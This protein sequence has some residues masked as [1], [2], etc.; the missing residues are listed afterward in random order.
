MS[1]TEAADSATRK[2]LA[3]GIIG[4]SIFAILVISG[5]AIG[6]A[7]SSRAETSRLVFSAV[8]P[9]LGTWVGTVLAFYFARDN[10]Q[11]AT[12]ST[13]RLAGIDA[14]TPVANVM[15]PEADFVAYDMTPGQAPADI[16]LTALRERM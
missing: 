10:L 3:A 5:L 7:G 1:R 2:W 14:G 4:A 9:L 6:L 8:L 16:P 12:E 13:L 15:I 11:A